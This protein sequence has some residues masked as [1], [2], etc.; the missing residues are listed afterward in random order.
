MFLQRLVVLATI[1]AA[2]TA[3]SRSLAAQTTTGAITGVVRDAD[4]RVV[5]GA[6]I[7]ARHEGT[8]VAADAVSDAQGLYSLR[9]LAVGRYTVSAE[10]AGFQTFQSPGV[11]VRVNDEV[12]LDVSLRVGAVTETLTVSG[13]ARVV[14]TTSSTLRT[15]VDQQRIENLPLNGRNPTQ[16]MTLV[17]G[18]LPDTTTSLT[19]GAT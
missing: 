16:L 9:G 7:R 5:P 19:S 1:L 11:V 4:G 2:L 6:T 14:D 8:N 3:G 18:V 15:V 10:L 13:S 12:R 17:A